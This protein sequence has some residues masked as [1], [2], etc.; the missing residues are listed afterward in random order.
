MNLSRAVA[1]IAVCAGASFAIGAAPAMAQGGSADVRAAGH[2]A[3][4]STWKLKAK[5]DAGRVQ[6]EFEVDSNRVGQTW[7]VAITDNAVRVFSG[8]RVTKAPSGSFTVAVRPVNRAGHD[9]FVARARNTATGELCVG[10]V[11]L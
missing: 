4:A 6:V 5:P 7:S 9:A 3:A 11:T 8:S 2:C 1:V 10:R